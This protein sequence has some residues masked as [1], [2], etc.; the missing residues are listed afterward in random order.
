MVPRAASN[1][2]GRG[3]KRCR[4]ISVHAASAESHCPVPGH[5]GR[6]DEPGSVCRCRGVA[7]VIETLGELKVDWAV[8]Q[9]ADHLTDHETIDGAWFDDDSTPSEAARCALESIGTPEAVRVLASHPEKALPAVS[10]GARLRRLGDPQQ[11]ENF[12]ERGDALP[13]GSE[14]LRP[15]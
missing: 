5:G 9:I 13:R 6:E 10:V 8:A 15:R 3:T 11:P 7:P 4:L 14:I 1:V 12:F 2:A